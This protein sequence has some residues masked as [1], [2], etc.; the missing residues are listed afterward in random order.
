[1][2]LQRRAAGGLELAG[3]DILELADQRIPDKIAAN[4]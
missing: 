2:V 3:H 1:L 4:L